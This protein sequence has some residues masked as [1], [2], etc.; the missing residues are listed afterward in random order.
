MVAKALI[1]L[2]RSHREIQA[3]VLNCI[4]SMTTTKARN[5][6][7]EPFLRTF[8][9]RSSDPTHIKILKLEI[10]TNLSSES[11]IGIILREFQ[12]YITGHVST[13][14]FG[15]WVPDS[16]LLRIG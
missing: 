8:F 4:A 16:V 12:S 11:N 1:R 2:L 13:A 9:V 10:I 14:L 7:F 5:N 15:A 3:I 6:M